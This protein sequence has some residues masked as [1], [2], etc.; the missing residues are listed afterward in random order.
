MATHA[1]RRRERR[2]AAGDSGAR[3]ARRRH[4][5]PDGAQHGH[6]R[7]LDRQRRPGGRAIRPACSASNATIHTDR[8]TIAADEFFT[9]LYETALQPGELI[10]AVSFPIGAE[11]GLR[12]V[13]AA[14]VALRADRRVRRQTARAA[15]AS[16]SPAPRRTCSA[17]REIENALAKSFTPEAAKAVK[18]PTDRHQR[19]PA[20]LG[21]VPRGDDQRDRFA[22]GGGGAGALRSA[23]A[24]G[25]R[26]TPGQA[27][28]STH[29]CVR[30]RRG[31]LAGACSRRR[32]LGS[33]DHLAQPGLT[34][35]R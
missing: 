17:R 30:S 3:R 15:C 5:R 4:R 32:M 34:K 7:R 11:G 6:D 23:D 26:R 10:T 21:R 29:G 14:G 22:R 27:N 18:M 12:Q 16:P 9:G 1:E 20:R 13:Q 28:A 31:P 35:E 24:A 19:R 2:R 25:R 33:N 8:R